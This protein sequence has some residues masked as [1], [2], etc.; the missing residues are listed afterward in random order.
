MYGISRSVLPQLRL[1]VS[2]LVLWLIFFSASQAESQTPVTVV[3]ARKGEVTEKIPVV[4]SLVAREEV[5]VRP[6]IEGRVIEHILAEIGQRVERGQLLALIDTTEARMLLDKNSVSML[7]ARAAAEVEESRLEVAAVSEAEAR[8]V[9]ERSRALQPRGAVSQ[10]LLDE[11]ENAHA[12]AVAEL[13]LARQSLALAEA[14]AELIARERKEI[15][16]TIERST[17]RA[18]DAGLVL[19]RTA[20]IGAMTSASANPLFVI[21]KDAEIEFSTQVTETSF[22]RLDEGMRA[23]I[24]LPGYEGQLGGRLRLNAAQVDLVTRSGEVRI[25]LDEADGLKPGVFAR[26]SINAPARRNI[27]LPGSAVNTASGASNVFVVKDGVVDRRDVT[28]GIRQEGFVEIIAGVSDG[29]MVV[30]KSGGFLKAQE[31]VRPVMAMSE[32]SVSDHMASALAVES[33]EMAR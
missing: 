22:L 27:L 29:E 26:G 19:K 3:V 24:S 32:R 33:R 2:A 28:V 13:R 31:K 9:L 25:E 17:V 20:R 16:L 10:Q 12:R 23:Q 5:E 7:R 4:G 8:K 1:A 21:A 18:P 11:H 14:D 6:F 15:E 30:L